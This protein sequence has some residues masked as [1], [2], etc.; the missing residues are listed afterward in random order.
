[1][2]VSTMKESGRVIKVIMTLA[3]GYRQWGIL[4][5][6]AYVPYINPKGPINCR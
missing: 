6:S 1:M 4:A 3:G 2:T 5:E